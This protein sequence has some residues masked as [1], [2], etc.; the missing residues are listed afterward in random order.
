LRRFDITF[1]LNRAIQEVFP[2]EKGRTW[3]YLL[4]DSFYNRLIEGQMTDTH[5]EY[6]MGHD[7]GMRQHYYDVNRREIR[8]QYLRCHFNRVVSK[9]DEVTRLEKQLEEERKRR[10][11]LEERIGR[12]DEALRSLTGYSIEKTL[13][14]LG[15]PPDSSKKR[16][17]P[18]GGTESKSTK[19]EDCDHIVSKDQLQTYLDQGWRYVDRIGSNQFIVRR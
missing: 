12:I 4:R 15:Y 3:P 18:P 17:V 10:A 1:Q 19:E 8:E 16:I 9:T 14:D 7:L 13:E 6:L 11:E 5:R 2:G